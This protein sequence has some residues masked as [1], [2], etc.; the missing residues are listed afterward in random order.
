MTE[1]PTGE[2]VSVADYE[3]LANVLQ[4]VLNAAAVCFEQMEAQ[5]LAA[6]DANAVLSVCAT[7]GRP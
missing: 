2:Y 1:D 3:K 7:L 4:A 6:S 5:E